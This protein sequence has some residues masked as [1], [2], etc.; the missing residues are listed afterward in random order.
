MNEKIKGYKMDFTTKTITI[1]KEFAETA[2]MNPESDQG[3]IL[4]NARSLCPDLRIAYK[5]HTPSKR[6]NTYKGMTYKKM[7]GY[8]KLYENADELLDTFN[9]IKKASKIQKNSYRYVLN[10]FLKQFPDYDKLPEIKNGKLYIIPF[11]P[12]E[13]DNIHK[14][15]S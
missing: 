14:L 13:S 8:I 11:K 6:N 2:L 5:T 12:A 15:A 9:L 4:E 7:E 3:K 10:W 1:T